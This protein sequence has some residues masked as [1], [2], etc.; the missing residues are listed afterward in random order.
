[1]ADRSTVFLLV[2]LLVCIVILAIFGMKYFAA[3][4]V[5][6]LTTREE[7]RY[8]EIAARAAKSQEEG[9]A[10]LSLLQTNV[11]AIEVRLMRVETILKQV[12]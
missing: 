8:R 2:T 4:R 10:S 5:A 11:A 6:R 12:E 1:M 3:A 7:D 9:T